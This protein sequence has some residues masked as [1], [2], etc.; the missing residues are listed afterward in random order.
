MIEMI[1]I[2]VYLFLED[3]SVDGNEKMCLVGVFIF[4]V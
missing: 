2:V 3:Y 1:G 4:G